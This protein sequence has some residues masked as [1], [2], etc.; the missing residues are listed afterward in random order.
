[1]SE[2]IV[3]A[4]ID[5]DVLH[6][7]AGE[8]ISAGKKIAADTGSL[9][10]AALIGGDQSLASQ[11]ISLGA[12]KVYVANDDAI[13]EGVA[14]AYLAVLHKICIDAEPT[15]VLTSKTPIG[16]AVGPRL[17]YRLGSGIAQDCTDVSADSDSRRVTATRPVYGGNAMA[18]FTF[19]DNAPQVGI[20]RL[21]AFEAAAPD[22]SRT[23]EVIEFEVSLDES[24]IKS[25]LVETVK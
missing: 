9:V 2:I 18:K 19:A 4:E 22:S 15:V 25:K 3:F 10:S 8:L 21:K 24:D 5:G 16:R 11:A 7:T 23:G 1:M 12:D 13:Q 14:D 20:M 6:S 17:A